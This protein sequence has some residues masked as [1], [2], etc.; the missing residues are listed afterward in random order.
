MSAETIAR[1]I[2]SGSVPSSVVHKS[3]K[4]RKSVMIVAIG[5]R[6]DIQPFIP[7]AISLKQQGHHPFMCVHDY[8]AD[9]ID[10]YGIDT[11]ILPDS[12]RWA[13]MSSDNAVNGGIMK[14]LEELY[15]I[16]A[17]QQD[18]VLDIVNKHSPDV[19]A[20]SPICDFAPNIYE[21]TQLPYTTIHL[22]PIVPATTEFI[23]PVID[24]PSFPAPFKFLNKLSYFLMFLL[25][26]PFRSKHR[27]RLGLRPVGIFEDWK[28]RQSSPTFTALS[29]SIIPQ[30]KDYASSVIGGYL[31]LRSPTHSLSP[32]VTAFLDAPNASKP[33]YV[34]FGSMTFEWTRTFFLGMQSCFE[35]E[36]KMKENEKNLPA[37]FILY[38]RRLSGMSHSLTDEEK[39]PFAKEI[40]DGTV[41]LVTSTP[42]ELLFPRCSLIVHHGGSGTT[43]EALHSGSPQ[44]VV[45]FLADQFFYGRKVE[46]TGVG[47]RG[48]NAKV[49][50]PEK[51]GAC[52][53]RVYA[54]TK[55]S[56]KAKKLG[57]QLREEVEGNW[58]RCVRWVEAVSEGTDV[59]VKTFCENPESSCYHEE[60]KVV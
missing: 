53:A 34:G 46:E 18:A 32:E 35:N 8:S 30:P 37:R 22:C 15:D 25:T 26:T 58:R 12:E 59:D 24:A 3:N 54:S 23:A 38:V 50:T 19:V 28:G 39:R 29:T 1:P 43:A 51:L 10:S 14:L 6:G 17:V 27:K 42:H 44:V 55:F 5:S 60:K 13:N 49:L 21:L 7:L 56:E 47:V 20:Y 57:E 2:S 9:W 41:L 45:P 40:Q 31:L 36:S 33:I 11:V 4:A 52:I 48:P 16:T